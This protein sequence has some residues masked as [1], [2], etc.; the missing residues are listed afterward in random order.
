MSPSMVD[1]PKRAVDYELQ[2][3]LGCGASARVYRAL[4][5]PLTEEVAV[6][7]MHLDVC[8]DTFDVATSYLAQELRVMAECEHPNVLS[9]HVS[10][11]H[12]MC[13]WMVIPLM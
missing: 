9:C 3:I 5:L 11:L 10:F 13:V 2:E 8:G 6:K 12:D 7:V 1:W 4:C